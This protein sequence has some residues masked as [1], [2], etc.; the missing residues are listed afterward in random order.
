M[1]WPRALRRPT[2]L[3]ARLPRPAR[4]ARAVLSAFLVALPGMILMREWVEAITGTRPPATGMGWF[5]MVEAVIVAGAAA[6]MAWTLAWGRQSGLGWAATMRVSFG[7]TVPSSWWSTPAVT[8][9]LAPSSRGVRPPDRDVPADHRRAI[10]EL[11]MQLPPSASRLG[12]RIT[13]AARRTTDALELCDSEI[14]TLSPHASTGELDRLSAQLGALEEGGTRTSAEQR[15]L[16]ELLRRQ[17]EVVRRIRVRCELVSQRRTRLLTRLRGLWTQA[18]LLREALEAGDS[19]P[20][21]S[22]ERIDALCGEIDRELASEPASV[23]SP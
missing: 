18:S 4:V 10:G 6:V 16:S 13:A 15:E 21:A 9:L 3:W 19:V 14:A 23:M 2:D 17:L 12:A 22:S 1:W 8:K 5:A 11:V 20:T 7:A